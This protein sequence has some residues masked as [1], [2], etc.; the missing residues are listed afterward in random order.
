MRLNFISDYIYEARVTT[1]L[2][3]L[4][5]YYICDQHFSCVT[6]LQ[7]TS[8]PPIKCCVVLEYRMTRLDLMRTSRIEEMR[9]CNTM[10]AR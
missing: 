5:L 8:N 10:V 4:E 2:I 3:I 1:S 7:M 6:L 9:D